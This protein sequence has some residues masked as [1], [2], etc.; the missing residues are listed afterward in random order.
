[1]HSNDENSLYMLFDMKKCLV[2]S[3]VFS[4][5]CLMKFFHS[6]NWSQRYRDAASL[7]S[8]AGGQTL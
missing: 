6:F 2:Q 1:M 8:L 3:Y 5:N 4:I 7:K